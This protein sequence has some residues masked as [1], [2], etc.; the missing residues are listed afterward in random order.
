MTEEEQLASDMRAIWALPDGV[1]ARTVLRVI[2][3]AG[4]FSAATDGSEGRDLAVA[5]QA[6]KNLGLDVLSMF[7]RG[8]PVAHPTGQ[9][10]LTI[11][12]ALRE[13]ATKPQEKPKRDRYDRHSDDD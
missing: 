9:P 2:Q 7:E 3:M 8:Q 1:A 4:I 10:L 5:Q 11:Y 6:R 12:H 13:E